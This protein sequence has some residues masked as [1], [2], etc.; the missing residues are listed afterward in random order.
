M[1]TVLQPTYA[2]R[3]RKFMT[4]IQKHLV[5][6]GV[7]TPPPDKSGVAGGYYVWL[8]F[9]ENVN[10]SD[11]TRVAEQE[12]RLLVHPGSL[13]LVEG[14]TSEAQKTFLNGIRVCFVWVEEQFLD[15]GVERLAAVILSLSDSSEVHS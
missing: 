3:Y 2:R 5:P 8:Q 15:E 14:D 4:A 10:A 12:H 1:H 7:T 9:P 13:F 6:L 11:V